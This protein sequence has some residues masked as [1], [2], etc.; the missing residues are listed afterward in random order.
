MSINPGWRVNH[1]ANQPSL[2]SQAVRFDGPYINDYRLVYSPTALIESPSRTDGFT[3]NVGNHAN[4]SGG[5]PAANHAIE[6]AP[7]HSFTIRKNM[8]VVLMS[9]YLGNP[10]RMLKQILEL[11]AGFDLATKLKNPQS[12]SIRHRQLTTTQRHHTLA[13]VVCFEHHQ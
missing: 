1:V 11:P 4:S 10:V 6:I 7:H 8:R 5:L 12:V 13:R 9:R 2:P 3:A